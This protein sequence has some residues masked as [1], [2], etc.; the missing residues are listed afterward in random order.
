MLLGLL[1]LLGLVWRQSDLSL[2][3]IAHLSKRY[4]DYEIMSFYNGYERI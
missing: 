2:S 3:Q 1:R 4:D